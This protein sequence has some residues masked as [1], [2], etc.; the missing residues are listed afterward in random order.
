MAYERITSLVKH[1]NPGSALNQMYVSFDF[2]PLAIL[3]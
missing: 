2:S 3:R 1:L